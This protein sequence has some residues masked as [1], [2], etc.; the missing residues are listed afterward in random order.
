MK[1]FVDIRLRQQLKKLKGIWLNH[2]NLWDRPDIEVDIKE[3]I[4]EI[5]DITKQEKIDYTVFINAHNNYGWAVV[6][7]EEDGQTFLENPIKIEFVTPVDPENPT[8]IYHT[9]EEI[10]S[11]LLNEYT[12][13][14]PKQKIEIKRVLED[15]NTSE[16]NEL[17]S[18]IQRLEQ[19]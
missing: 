5:N 18:W 15:K 10:R 9:K 19:S 2:K 7:M 14:K 8:Y 16:S 12:K 3:L 17:L 11:F 1:Q 4:Q 13:K 6:G